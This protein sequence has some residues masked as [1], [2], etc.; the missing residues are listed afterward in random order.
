MKLWVN[1]IFEYSAD[2]LRLTKHSNSLWLEKN[3]KAHPFAKPGLARAQGRLEC[4]T[5]CD[6]L[7][8]LKCKLCRNALHNCNI[9]DKM[10]L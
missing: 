2:G 10:G 9:K 8:L 6:I 1:G 7:G 3:A 4:G 5:L